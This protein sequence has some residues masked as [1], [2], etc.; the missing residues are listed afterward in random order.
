[1]QLKH[2]LS[3]CVGF[4]SLLLSSHFWL[5]VKEV[6]YGHQHV[7][8]GH[9]ATPYAWEK[10]I[11]SWDWVEGYSLTWMYPAVLKVDIVRKK[12]IAKTLDDRYISTEGSFFHLGK[13]KVD[14]PIFNVPDENVH[15]AMALMKSLGS[16]KSIREYPSGTIEVVL[17][18]K[19]KVMLPSYDK[20]KYYD[21]VMRDMKNS[22]K[23]IFCDFRCKQYANCH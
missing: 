17:Q 12:A 8:L 1:M 15:I 21:K 18:S 2:K 7:S 11:E 22:D 4:V 23:N 5:P 20:P 6:W 9:M 16:I 13:N 14:V 19:D 10:Q 3:G